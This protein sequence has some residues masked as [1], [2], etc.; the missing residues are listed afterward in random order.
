MLPIPNIEYL[1]DQSC[2]SKLLKNS[3]TALY[4]VYMGFAII[5]NAE[6]QNQ[7]TFQYIWQ[8][9]T[10]HILPHFFA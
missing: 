10:E 6:L 9:E 3:T 8:E 1:D 7:N 5:P 2:L 4:I